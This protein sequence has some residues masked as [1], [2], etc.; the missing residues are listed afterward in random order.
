MNGSPDKKP[1]TMEELV[2]RHVQMCM[3]EVA[4]LVEECK[5]GAVQPVEIIIV[6]KNKDGSFGFRANDGSLLT[7]IGLV[8]CA[9]GVLLKQALG[10]TAPVVPLPVSHHA[11]GRA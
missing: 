2:E 7:Q 3:A 8:E 11:P 6:F 1:E 10:P 9:G 5:T 4:S